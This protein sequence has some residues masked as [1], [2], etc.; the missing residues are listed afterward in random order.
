MT[1]AR[2]A[3]ATLHPL[4]RPAR[5]DAAA[6]ALL[7]ILRSRPDRTANSWTFHEGA[8]KKDPK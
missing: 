1:M 5:A 4:V 7:P 2:V 8:W 6:E 3:G